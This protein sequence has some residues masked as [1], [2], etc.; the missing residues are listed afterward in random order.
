MFYINRNP[1]REDGELTFT[2]LDSDKKVTVGTMC[3]AHC[4]RHWIYQPGSGRRRGWCGRCAAFTCGSDKC[5]KCVPIEQWLENVEGG[6]P[7]DFRK[8]IVPSGW[9]R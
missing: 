2:P 5:S 6:K 8:I 9:E 3:C 1:I 7:E 4:N